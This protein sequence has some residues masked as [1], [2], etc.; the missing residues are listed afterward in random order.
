MIRKIV[1]VKQMTHLAAVCTERFVI[2]AGEFAFQLG[3]ALKTAEAGLGEGV[4]D[5]RR[6]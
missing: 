2:P 1:T 3:V 5:E 6:N 4:L